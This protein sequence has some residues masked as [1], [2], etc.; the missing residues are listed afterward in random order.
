MKL[1]ILLCSAISINA[2]ADTVLYPT[3][4]LGNIQYHKDHVVIKS[5]GRVVTVNSA[6]NAQYH[7]QQY[8]IVDGKVKAVDSIGNIQHHKASVKSK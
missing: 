1:L 2:F 8:K 3:D 7:K 6:G 4:H 5:D